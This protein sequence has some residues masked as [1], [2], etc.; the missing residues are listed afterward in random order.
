MGDFA[1]PPETPIG[2]LAAVRA[3]LLAAANQRN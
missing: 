2:D 3:I 1:D